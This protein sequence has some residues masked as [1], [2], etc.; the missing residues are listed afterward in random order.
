MAFQASVSQPLSDFLM[1]SSPGCPGSTLRRQPLSSTSEV[2]YYYFVKV[3][4]FW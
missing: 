4:K 1:H 2:L 3:G